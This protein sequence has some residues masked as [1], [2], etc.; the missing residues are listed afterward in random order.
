MATTS[1]HAPGVSGNSRYFQ[2]MAWVILLIIVAVFVTNLA[3]GRSSFAVPWPYHV[4]GLVF[5]GWVAIFLAQNTFIAGGNVALHRGSG[6]FSSLG[7]RLSVVLGF[8][9]FAVRS[10]AGR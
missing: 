6:Q 3:L 7:I 10:E 1:E 4:H 9:I 5:F 2:I 8:P